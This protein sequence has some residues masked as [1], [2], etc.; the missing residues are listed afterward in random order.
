MPDLLIAS[1][2]DQDHSGGLRSFLG[3][4]Q[5]ERLVSGTPDELA[6]R[7]R[8]GHRVRSCHH[9]PD[10][11]WDGVS[12]R[13][14][15]VAS[16]GAKASTNNRSCVLQVSGYQRTL[17][18]G[19]IEA[20]QE[21]KLI[22]SLGD[23]L[24]ADVL[25]APHHGSSTSSSEQFVSRVKPSHVIFTVAAGNRWGF[26]RASVISRYRAIAAIQ[27]RSDIDGAISLHST[28]NGLRVKTARRSGHRI[29]RDR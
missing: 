5:P 22:Q 1:H 4:Y 12:F 17:I 27:Y 28:A 3:N 24:D 14:L 2:V 26:P 8:L 23:D 18:A 21:G 25:L 7:F 15:S 29:W 6:E 9:Y 20:E 10:W 11:R 16:T 19:D 13:F